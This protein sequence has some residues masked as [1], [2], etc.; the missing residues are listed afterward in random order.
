MHQLPL[1][2]QKQIDDNQSLALRLSYRV[3]EFSPTGKL[4]GYRLEHVVRSN[5]VAIG[6]LHELFGSS[7]E[8]LLEAIHAK[9]A[10]AKR[11]AD[12]FE[13]TTEQATL[14]RYAGVSTLVHNTQAKVESNDPRWA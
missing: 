11:I 5:V 4:S 6:D 9:S 7:V 3:P 8:K 13:L 12:K 2:T 1:I 14:V 10:G